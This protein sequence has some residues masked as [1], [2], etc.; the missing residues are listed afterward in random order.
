MTPRLRSS[1]STLVQKRAPSVFSIQRPRQS[2]PEGAESRRCHSS[3]VRVNRLHDLACVVG[4]GPG[5]ERDWVEG[6]E[7]SEEPLPEVVGGGGVVGNAGSDQRMSQLQEDC[8]P[9]AEE[10][11]HR[12]LPTRRITLPAAK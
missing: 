2:R 8:R 6:P 7:R 1:V 11:G 10:R 12:W 9:A 3:D 5:A 4:L